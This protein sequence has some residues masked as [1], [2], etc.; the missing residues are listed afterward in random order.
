[1]ASAPLS[2]RDTD[3]NPGRGALP[4]AVAGLFV[5]LAA[6]LVGR[7]ETSLWM[8]NHHG[9]VI[10]KALLALDRGRVEL[11][12]F[13]YPPLPFLLMLP[14]PSTLVAGLLA[15]ACGGAIV[16]ILTRTLL[17]ASLPPAAAAGAV[18]GL[19]TPSMFFLFTQSLWEALLLVL[20]LVGWGQAI[21]FIW[22]GNVRAGAIAG[23]TVGLAFLASY[24]AMLFALPFALAALLFVRTDRR[25]A[26]PAAAVMILFPALAALLSWMYLSWVFT[27]DFLS[28]TRDPSSSLFAF[29]RPEAADLPRDWTSALSATGRDLMMA[30]LYVV[31]AAVLAWYR[32]LRVP[33][34]L[35]FGVFVLGLRAFGF[36]LPDYFAVVAFTIV[37]LASTPAR[38]P[39]SVVALVVLTALV[40]GGINWRT[41]LRGEAAEWQTVVVTGVARAADREELAVGQLLA[42][43]P[44]RSILV[45][46]RADY[47]VIARAGSARPF[48]TSVD[49]LYGPAVSQPARFVPSMLA[50]SRGYD[51][52]AEASGVVAGHPEARLT[53]LSPRWSLYEWSRDD[54]A[55]RAGLR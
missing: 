51:R 50:R 31:M 43:R 54:G 23:L 14:K 3:P 9:H 22:R 12:G 40:Q 32:P 39:R 11:I 35:V 48:L 47:R 53:R 4:L 8:S 45:D 49:P 52:P 7:A 1:M 30:P 19:A 17:R 16:W 18:L 20:L 42:G 29:L 44:A 26:G 33:V 37:A 28:F 41:P 2:R 46:D 55:M 34:L 5:V 15:A 24:Y 36:V 25:G 21:E 27:G 38:L 6:A 13:M 10:E